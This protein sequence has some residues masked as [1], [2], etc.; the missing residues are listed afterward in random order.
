MEKRL[1]FLEKQRAEFNE[2]SKNLSGSIKDSVIAEM[3][4]LQ[5][6]IEAIK[7]LLLSEREERKRII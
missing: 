2:L 4:N 7:Q 6:E 5:F 1:Q 3:Q